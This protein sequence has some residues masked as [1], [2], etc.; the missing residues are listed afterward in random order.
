MLGEIKLKHARDEVQKRETISHIFNKHIPKCPPVLGGLF[1]RSAMAEQH[2]EQFIVE[3]D[4][5]K[6]C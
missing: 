2:V 6:T 4:S 3:V 1:I 5:V